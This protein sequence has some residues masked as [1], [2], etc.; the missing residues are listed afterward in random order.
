MRLHGR[1]EHPEHG[2]ADVDFVLYSLG[3]AAYREDGTEYHD[4]KDY[5]E[6]RLFRLKEG[7]LLD[8]SEVCSWLERKGWTA[9]EVSER[10]VSLKWGRG[11]TLSGAVLQYD[12]KKGNARIIVDKAADPPEYRVFVRKGNTLE[13]VKPP[14]TKRQRKFPEGWWRLKDAKAAALA[15]LNGDELPHTGT[16]PRV[17]TYD[18]YDPEEEGYGSPEQWRATFE[19]RL[20]RNEAEK[21]LDG[22]SPE[23]VL[24]LLAGATQK[25]IKSA[26]RKLISQWHPDKH[27]NSI[28]A[29][30]MARKIQAAY[31]LLRND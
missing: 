11:S 4:R 18:T 3:W 16:K 14:R 17:L 25:E 22:E 24:D 15:A 9:K 28:T 30:D 21:V 1:I 12:E 13:M 7:P 2:D 6:D 20:G 10:V 23:T 29:T 31:E 5:E 19:A 26:Y 8:F 27:A